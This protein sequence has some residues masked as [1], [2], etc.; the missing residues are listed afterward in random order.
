MRTAPRV[1]FDIGGTFA[2][3]VAMTPDGALRTYKLLSLPEQVA[4]DVRDRLLD[5]MGASGAGELESLVHGTTI[6][7]NAL[8][9]GKGAR[10]GL[11]TTTGFRDELEM[12]RQARPGIY[13]F[14]WQRRPPL[15]PR[16]LRREVNERVTGAGEVFRPLDL[17]DARAA[18]LALQVQDIEA[19]AICFIN[20]FANPAHEREVADLAREL[21]PDAALSV[22]HEVLPE[23]REYERTSTTAVNA[24][25]MPVVERYI[26]GLEQTLGGYCSRGLRIVQSN[27]GLTTA[28]QARRFPV[29]LVESGPAAG[30]LACAVL[31]REVGLDRAVSFDMGGTTVKACLIEDGAPVEKTELEVG[32]EANASARYSR[33][34]GYAISVPSLDIV[35]AGAGGG[36]IAW[37]DDGG[38]LRV[39]P[40][41]AGAAPGPVCYGRGATEPTITDANVAIGF[42]NPTAIAGGSVPIDRPAALTAFERALCPRLDLPPL[43]AAH[44]VHTVANAAMTRAI[45]AVTTERGRNPRDYTLVAFGGSGPVHAAGLAEALDMRRVYVP[46]YPGLFSAL[47]LLLADLRYDHVRSVPGRLDALGA[48]DLLA[49]FETI[50]A[51]IGEEMR[52][53]NI[54]AATVRFERYLDLRYQRQTSE[55]T[56]AVPDD[57]TAETLVAS[58]TERFHAAHELSYGYRSADEAI[59]VVSLRL[60]ATAPA[61][62]ISFG[63]AAA[64]FRRDPGNAT[65]STREAYFGPDHGTLATRIITRAGLIDRSCEGPVVI[66]AFDTTVVVPPGWRARLDDYASIVLEREP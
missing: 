8:L 24:Y 53:D 1:S 46:L 27:G 48:D 43:A 4:G 28:E 3:V 54:D 5:V 59:A 44:G 52:Q 45:R 20:A 19:L 50:A 49:R 36:S 33:G 35:E 29:R 65:E 13:D 14:L 31:C 30:V 51:D 58:L 34:A 39:G 55:L 17:D 2:D 15:I 40:H 10:T 37:I 63:D 64:A 23:I 61:R 9:E 26:G 22:S 42:M 66:E 47:G 11:L 12:H 41:S 60:K 16:R 18:L 32:G 56:I 25:L 57:V 7:S 38:T 6:C 21:L 62:A